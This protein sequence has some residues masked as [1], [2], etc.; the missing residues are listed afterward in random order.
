MRTSPNPHGCV[1]TLCRILKVEKLL[2]MR[3][4]QDNRADRDEGRHGAR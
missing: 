1:I 3:G 4:V 2:I